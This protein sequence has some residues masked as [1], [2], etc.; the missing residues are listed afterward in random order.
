[1]AAV[2]A[3][4]V[5][6]RSVAFADAIFSKTGFLELSVDVAGKYVGAMRQALTDPAQD[7]ETFVRNRAT[8]ELQSMS[9][10]TPGQARLRCKGR[11]IGDLLKDDAGSSERGI[12]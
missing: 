4:Q 2:E 3:L 1:M 9:V 12:S 7:L 5:V 11:W 10:E 6:D 8:V